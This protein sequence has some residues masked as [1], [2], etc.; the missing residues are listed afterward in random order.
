VGDDVTRVGGWIAGTFAARELRTLGYTVE[1][2]PTGP[3]RQSWDVDAT[4]TVTETAEYLTVSEPTVRAW[5]A[6]RI[7]DVLPA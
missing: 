3:R 2:M 4:G 1:V 5:L 6:R 7:L